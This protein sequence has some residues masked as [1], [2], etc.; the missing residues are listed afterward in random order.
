M[1]RLLFQGV[2]LHFLII[3]HRNKQRALYMFFLNLQENSISVREI[4]ET[5]FRF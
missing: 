4:D 1:Q 2:T 5:T 3:D